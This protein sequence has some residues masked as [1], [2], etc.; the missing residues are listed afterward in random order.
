MS[1]KAEKRLGR[2]LLPELPRDVPMPKYKY[3]EDGDSKSGDAKE[4]DKR[5]AMILAGTT[6]FGCAATRS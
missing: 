4:Q 1:D 3:Q 6:T 2:T 5:A